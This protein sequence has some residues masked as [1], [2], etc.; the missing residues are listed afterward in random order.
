[1]PSDVEPQNL[2][3]LAEPLSG[4]LSLPPH[5]RP[6]LRDFRVEVA[7]GTHIPRLP[8]LS[9]PLSGAAS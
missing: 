1:M 9:A 6:V 3:P 7:L 2:T 4:R 8:H 5:V